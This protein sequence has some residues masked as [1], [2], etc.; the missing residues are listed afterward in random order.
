MNRKSSK[1]TSVIGANES[2]GAR[3]FL[4]VSDMADKKKTALKQS[5][6]CTVSLVVWV[7][8]GA[9][10]AHA[11][12]VT[13]YTYDAGD[14]IQQVTDPRG[15][16]TSYAHDGLG[17]EWQQVSPDTGTT[18]FSYD[19]NGRLSS[20]TRSDGG[21]TTYGYDG[22]GRRTSVSA[23]GLTQTW[24]YD[25]CTHGIGRLCS[26]ADATGTT[27]YTYSPEG[28]LTGR[29][30]SIGG[31]AYSLGYAY[32]ALGQV[33]TVVY[34]DGNQALYTYAYGVVSTVQ[35]QVGSTVS[36]AATGVTYQPNDLAMTQWTSGNGLTNA[37]AYDADG[38]LTS[39]NVPG[40]Q[41]L[42]LTYDAANRLV[43]IWNG[44]DS[45]MTQSFGYDTMSRLSSVYSGA[46]NEAFQYD[47]NGNRLSQTL[48]GVS[49]TVAPSASN[50]QIVN[51][52]GGANTTYGY[53]AKGNLT[54]VSGTPTFTYDAF[55]RLSSAGGGTYYVGPEGQ[56]L[57]KT[58]SG[59]STY[60]APDSTGP[61]MAENP[62]SAWND[63]V[64]LNGRLIGRIVSGQLQAIHDDQIG[65]PEVMTDAGKNIV[66]R[67]RNFA[68]DRSVTVTNA[69]PFNV[70]F[71]GQYYDAESGLW[72]N[73][74]R[75]YSPILG[76]Y[77]ES[78]PIGLAGGINTYTY[79]SG[80][81][82]TNTDPHGLAVGTV[83]VNGVLAN[84][85]GL[86]PGVGYY[87][88]SYGNYG[89]YKSFGGGF[90]TLGNASIGIGISYFGSLGNG[91]P[92]SYQDFAGPFLN[93]SGG[94]GADGLSGSVDG[95]IDPMSPTHFGGGVTLGV[96]LPGRSA[97]LSVTNTE[98]C[99][100]GNVKVDI[101]S[102]ISNRINMTMMG[103]P[104]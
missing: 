21:Q 13:H 14:H 78:D 60:F 4:W 41:S 17:Q 36:N 1:D 54:T 30:F 37:L 66:W 96:G 50:N 59:T 68:F 87:V 12:T 31:T 79:V 84:L 22:I 8:I 48:N 58:V 89:T 9:P 26:A 101:M 81:P 83:S 95:Y 56:R 85:T 51:L 25:N 33:T 73:G 61:L 92:V 49:S 32:N 91:D 16:V 76:V 40:T 86:T 47:A 99:P 82:L 70:G 102:A 3:S 77:I 62:G 24:T 38:R 52:S 42:G 103:A 90:S 97:S 46:D 11:Q 64:W 88:D 43:G 15:L 2:D 10:A 27:S 72:N 80:N 69:S 98:V 104:W 19:G 20:M 57:R 53:D 74:L 63:Y 94:G 23:G 5:V 55:N 100:R 75:D 35:I 44:A 18:S 93:A 34:P 6:V 45:A 28:W 65:R 29:G 7:G 67:V 71:P 39:I